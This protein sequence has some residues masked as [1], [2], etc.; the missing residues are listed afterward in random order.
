MRLPGES[1][2]D[3]DSEA[4]AWRLLAPWGMTPETASL[5]RH[6]LYTFQARW[7]DQW[8]KGRCL[9]AGDAAHQMPPFAGQGMCAGLRDAANLAWKLDLV[10]RGLAPDTLLDTYASERVAQ[11]R[12]VVAFSIELGTVI[13]VSDPAEA[14]ARDAAMIAAVKDRGPTPPLPTPAIGPGLLVDGDPLAGHLF[15]QGEVRRG[16]ATGR[17]DDVVGRGFTLLSPVADPAGRLAPELA[18]FFASLGGVSAHVAPGGPVHDLHGTYA[19]WF[20]EN[21][22]GV[23]LQ[24]PD[25]H[26]FGTAP[27]IDGAATLVG[28]LRSALEGST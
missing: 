23:V 13:C 21:G 25:F 12:Q 22:V 27:A 24:R 14:A 8:R 26:V 17:F 11:V 28:R 2:A 5:E 15:P 4:T 3:L 19:R 1:V 18:A 16:E 6:A 20:A 10:L 9:L 7:V